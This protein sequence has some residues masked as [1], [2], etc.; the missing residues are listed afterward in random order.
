MDKWIHA[1]SLAAFS[2]LTLLGVVLLFFR[3]GLPTLI[4]LLKIISIRHTHMS[5]CS[6]RSQSLLQ[7]SLL[8][9]LFGVRQ[10]WLI[11]PWRYHMSWSQVTEKSHL[12]VSFH[13]ARS[14]HAGCQKRKITNGGTQLGTLPT[15]LPTFQVRCAYDYHGENK[16]SWLVLSLL[17]QAE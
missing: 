12:L 10:S 15:K 17:H 2:I 3:L 7:Y 8:L 1:L 6:G 4:K 5:C 13:K 11:R 9:F 16:H 14:C